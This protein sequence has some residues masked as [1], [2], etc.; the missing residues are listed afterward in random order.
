MYTLIRY[1]TERSLHMDVKV[2]IRTA[3][4]AHTG[5][6]TGQP[7]VPRYRP[8]PAQVLTLVTRR[9]SI[10]GPLLRAVSRL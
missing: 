7:R 10:P 4:L 1:I 8:R 3:T 5:R 9:E 2:G 6:T